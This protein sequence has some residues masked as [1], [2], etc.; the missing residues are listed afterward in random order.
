MLYGT[1]QHK[2]PLGGQQYSDIASMP[3]LFHDFIERIRSEFSSK[4]PTR[5]ELEV[6]G[7]EL[8]A[9]CSGVFFEES[10]YRLACPSEELIYELS[11]D[12]NGGASIYLVSDGA[13]VS[14]PPHEHQ[15]W[16]IVVGVQGEEFNV[17]YQSTG[18]DHRHVS[19]VGEHCIRAGDVL[20]M[21]SHEIHAIDADRGIHPTYHVHLYG[22]SLV[23]LPSFGS[24]CYTSDGWST[25]E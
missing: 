9:I 2:L 5:E 17:F 10:M 23:S 7:E 25:Y 14:T 22:H 21:E 6:V 20:V 12:P 4:I 19:R 15:T 16:A 11:V 24:R 13:G 1:Q 8:R 3:V 18:S